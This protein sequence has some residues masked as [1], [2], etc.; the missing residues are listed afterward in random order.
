MAW[1]VVRALGAQQADIGRS[2]LRK[3]TGF[4]HDFD[5]PSFRTL[6]DDLGDAQALGKLAWSSTSMLTPFF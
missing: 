5:R 4:T 6:R 1:K 2:T 3:A